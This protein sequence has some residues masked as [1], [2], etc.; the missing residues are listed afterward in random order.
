MV[1]DAIKTDL[2]NLR[3]TV[4][5]CTQTNQGQGSE[6]AQRGKEHIF[7]SLIAVHLSEQIE[8][9]VCV[10]GS[11]EGH[12]E[13]EYRLEREKRKSSKYVFCGY[14]GVSFFN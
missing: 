1:G 14:Y 4:T 6:E 5:P 8:A 3:S 9:K 2:I 12:G 10:C 7:T 13:M 11:E